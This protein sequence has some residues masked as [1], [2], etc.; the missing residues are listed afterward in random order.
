MPP[1]NWQLNMSVSATAKRDFE[2]HGPGTVLLQTRCY[3]STGVT[4][5]SNSNTATNPSSSSSY[6]SP[7]TTGGSYTYSCQVYV[8]D[9]YDTGQA[10]ASITAVEIL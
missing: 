1:G 6:S 3:K 8:D 2:S 9:K 7:Y 10:S 4:L 5:H